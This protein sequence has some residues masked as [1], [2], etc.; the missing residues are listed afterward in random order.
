MKF[1]LN[2]TAVVLIVGAVAGG[3]FLGVKGFEWGVH[4]YIVSH[5]E[6]LIEAEQAYAAK[7][8]A[9][10]VA[11]ARLAIQ[12]HKAEIFSDA[13]DPFVGPANAKVTVVQFA[14]YRCP[15]CKAEAAPAV[16][17]LIQKYP[18]VKFVFKE[19][20]IFGAPSQA[21]AHAALGAWK[22]GKY[23]PVYQAFM[24]EKTLDQAAINRILREQS[25]D[26]AKTMALG[27]G[28]ADAKQMLDIE[29]LA[30]QLGAQGTPAFII[31]DT[32]VPG[33]HMDEVEALIQKGR[34]G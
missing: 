30:I 8:D 25:L 13:R 33:A 34:K 24:A 9:A 29:R 22:Q 12:A 17:A 26:P 1:Q 16:L 21:A 18:D 23:L 20:P 28:A 5:P 6:V 11:K 15:H 10:M 3:T 27:S 31:G 19:W 4:H 14:D 7:Q 32:L 2:A